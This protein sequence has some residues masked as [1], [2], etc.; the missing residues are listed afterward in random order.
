MR[1]EF[2]FNAR[3][4]LSNLN[5][6]ERN[7]KSVAEEAAHDIADELIRIAS[8]ITP[9]DKGTL[10]RSHTKKV[11]IV[12]NRIEAEVTFSVREGDFNYALWIHEGIYNHGE[13]T[14]RRS[15]TT[16]WSGKR[17]YVGRKYLE[18]P[19]K[20]EQQAFYRHIARQIRNSL[21]G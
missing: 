3:D 17:Y 7:I 9:F 6:I 15:G 1:M 11:R 20:G 19:L 2:E 16:G 10:S 18:R 21:G 12:G 5:R 4:F 8:E 13:G 14:M